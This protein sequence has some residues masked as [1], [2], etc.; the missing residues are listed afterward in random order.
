MAM[1]NEKKDRE[2]VKEVQ[3]Y[4]RKFFDSTL[5]VDVLEDL[6][7]E[8]SYINPKA[9]K[10]DIKELHKLPKKFF[11]NKI[12]LNIFLGYFEN[13][14][15]G[16][17]RFVSQRRF[18]AFLALIYL[19]DFVN[20]SYVKIF[21]GK[22]SFKSIEANVDPLKIAGEVYLSGNFKETFKLADETFF[23]YDTLPSDVQNL[24]KMI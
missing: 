15:N 23:K 6:F 22:K 11:R 5:S 16:S 8:L 17:E 13:E 3:S 1:R 7:V 20:E 4:C 19:K 18:R 9:S 14:V 2:L 24:S 12:I 21:C 10:E